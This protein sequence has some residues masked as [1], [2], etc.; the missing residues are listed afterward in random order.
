MQLNIQ[1]SRK[2]PNLVRD[3]NVSKFLALVGQK[4][5]TLAHFSNFSATSLPK[6]V[7]H[8]AKSCPPPSWPVPPPIRALNSI[9]K[10]MKKLFIKR[11]KPKKNK[12][13]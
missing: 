9:L 5:V 1:L 6:I 12:L 3:L 2:W 4:F 7:S 13:Y 8:N 10:T 11:Q